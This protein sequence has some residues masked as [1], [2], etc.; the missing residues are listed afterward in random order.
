MAMLATQ[1]GLRGGKALFV[2]YRDFRYV[3]PFLVES[4]DLQR[5]SHAAQNADAV[6][7]GRTNFRQLR[8]Y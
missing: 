8:G 4:G 6:D 3:I 1:F 7:A 5:R 2:K